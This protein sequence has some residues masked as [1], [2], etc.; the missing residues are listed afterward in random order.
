MSR[1]LLR[2][3]LFMVLLGLSPLRVRAAFLGTASP[4]KTAALGGNLVAQPEGS[5]DLTENPAG[6]GSADLDLVSA[7]YQKLF[8]GVGQDDLATGSLAVVVPTGKP[9]GFGISWDHFGADHLTQDRW[10][11][12]WGNRLPL[13]PKTG[14]WDL[15]FSL[16]H[17]S[18]QYTLSVPLSSVSLSN[19]SAGAFSFGAG[20]LWEPL[21]GFTL[22][23]AGE[24]LTRPNLGVLGVD[25]FEPSFKWGVGYKRNMEGV[26]DLRATLAQQRADAKLET[27]GG[28]EWTQPK[29]GLSLRV[30]WGTRQGAVG[31]GFTRGPL[32]LDYAYVFSGS[33]AASLDGTGLP[34]SH[35][36]ELGW[37]WAK[38]LEP[39]DPEG[40]NALMRRGATQESA[41]RYV[42][43]LWTYRRALDKKPS[44]PAALSAYQRS[45]TGYNRARS[46]EFYRWGREAETRGFLLE[47]SRQY[48]WAVQLDPANA[49][50]RA[51]KTRV[52]SQTPTGAMADPRVV[53]WLQKSAALSTQGRR[54]EALDLVRQARSL[55]PGDPTLK[56]FEDDLSAVP[57]PQP[58]PVQVDPLEA[59]LMAESEIYLR[60]GRSDLAE[61]T[62]MRVL[63]LDPSNAGV[64]AK[65]KAAEAGASPIRTA[66]P[67]ER[68]RAQV[69]YETGL[70]AYL[71][72]DTRRAVDLWEKALDLDPNHA[73][74]MNNLVRAR[75]ELD[76]FK[77]P[78]DRKAP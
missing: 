16:S 42:E 57:T 44:D 7:R 29:V 77:S 47:A 25:R 2:A 61:E 12:A 1:S 75:L 28:L 4:P 51:A 33:G 50:Y 18:Q 35:L 56:A 13:P 8:A 3:S 6:L 30:G 17:L 73:N 19:L 22:G 69:L 23:L 10:R 66:S 60:K 20:F 71:A 27:E 78:E 65:L 46:A 45:L 67:T 40:Y 70:K 37:R 68:A 21:R 43:S 11:L 14:K 72:G 64:Q 55:Y 58:T 48:D 59:R 34:G 26:G 38:R 41:G 5:G 52:A 24:D 74:A 62:W 53:Q 31:F 39:E 54:A 49:D 63:E 32:V 76:Q 9:G 15:G 36:L